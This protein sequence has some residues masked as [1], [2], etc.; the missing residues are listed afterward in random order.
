MVNQNSDGSCDCE[1]CKKNIK[2]PSIGRCSCG[3]KMCCAAPAECACV[4]H[5]KK[6]EPAAADTAVAGGGGGGGGGEPDKKTAT[7]VF[8][9]YVVEDRFRVPKGI[10]LK[11]PGIEWGIKYG[12]LRVYKNEEEIAKIGGDW[13]PHAHYDWKRPNKS[14]ICEATDDEEEEE[15]EEA[16]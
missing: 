8:A 1:G 2:E 4:C 10:D 7:F 15:E 14:E 5:T 3:E 11:D 12:T 9:T 16:S 6:K 13:E